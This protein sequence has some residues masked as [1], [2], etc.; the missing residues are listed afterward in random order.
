VAA[1]ADVSDGDYAACV[2]RCAELLQA[3]SASLRPTKFSEEAL[4]GLLAILPAGKPI[5]DLHGYVQCLQLV[6]A[7]TAA[8]ESPAWG[9]FL[10]FLLAALS[11]LKQGKGVKCLQ[12]DAKEVAAQLGCLIA[13]NAQ[14]S[15]ARAAL[16]HGFSI[17]GDMLAN[18][19]LGCLVPAVLPVFRTAFAGL[20]AW[21]DVE[22]ARADLHA[23]LHCMHF[24]ALCRKAGI[25]E[26]SA[27]NE[28]MDL[29]RS[30]FARHFDAAA[31]LPEL[32]KMGIASSKRRRAT[33]RIGM[34]TAQLAEAL[35]KESATLNSAAI[36]RLVNAS[37]LPVGA[38][39]ADTDRH[40]TAARAR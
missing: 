30:S 12:K 25:G 4:E 13:L 35:V 28:A 1:Y 23:L 9:R 19:V 21:R 10:G 38:N 3:A 31:L 17:A 18:D 15:S 7:A 39:E 2:A 14:P 24:F 5:F 33:K 32:E 34:S 16:R 20:T 22:V 29:S 6:P 37:G 11:Q 36:A 27:V 8:S 26:T 40:A